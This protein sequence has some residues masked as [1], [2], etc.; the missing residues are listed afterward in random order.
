MTND[1]VSAYELP[2]PFEQQQMELERQY[3]RELLRQPTQPLENIECQST[4]TPQA[5]ASHS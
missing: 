5:P 3:R 4:H 1:L 2:V